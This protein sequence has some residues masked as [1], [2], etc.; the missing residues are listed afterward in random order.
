MNRVVIAVVDDMFFASKIRGTAEAL[1]LEVR[2]ARTIDDAVEMARMAA[3][4]LIIADL[5]GKRCDAFLL[6]EKLKSDESLREIPLLGFFSHVQTA[7][8]KRAEQARFDRIVPRSFFS[9][10]LAL[11]LEGKP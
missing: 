10:N 8:Q 11:I 5:H 7:L 3:P 2:F 4:N 1:G 6:A 9:K